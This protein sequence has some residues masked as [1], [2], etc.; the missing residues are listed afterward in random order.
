M[1]KMPVNEKDIG[2]IVDMPYYVGIPHFIEN[3]GWLIAHINPFLEWAAKFLKK[4]Q[5]FSI[6]IDRD[7]KP[8]K[9]W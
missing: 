1:N 3:G 2:T 6:F 7:L 4:R 9:N 5:T 8:D